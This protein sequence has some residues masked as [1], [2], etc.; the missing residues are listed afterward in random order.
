M[1]MTQIAGPSLG[2][3][4]VGP[5]A[6]RTPLR[7][8]S[9][10]PTGDALS[11]YSILAAAL[12]RTPRRRTSRRA[13][14]R[15]RRSGRSSICSTT[16]L[17]PNGGFTVTMRVANL[18]QTE[19]TSTR[20]PHAVAVA[21]LGLALHER[22][23]GRSG[24]GPLECRRRASRSATTTSRPATH[25]AIGGDTGGDK[26]ILY[27]GDQ[28]IQGDVN[29][30]TG[31]I[32]LSVPRFLLRALSGSTGPGERPSEVAA[33]VGSRFYDGT[34]FS[35]G[36]TI[37]PIQTLQSFLYP[38]DNTPS[39]D[40]LLPAPSGGGT[41]GVPCKIT[42]GGT[43]QTTGGKFSLNVHVGT[44]PKGSVSYR[45]ASTDFRSTSLSLATCADPSHA[46]I[47]GAGKNGND[48]VQF[49]LE[50]VDGGEASTNDAFSLTMTPGGN[51]SGTLSK[52]NIQIHKG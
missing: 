47:R 24:R 34:A 41:S 32:R 5:I 20:R 42:G 33:T 23:P 14:S 35:L 29:Q 6:N 28:P 45:D 22:L 26:C 9:V 43:L 10:D 25:L 50:V 17:S 48:P 30:A 37:S 8:S 7:T 12:G 36:N 49:V 52:G 1:A 38:L 51:R 18:A 19:L 39:M 11:S 16:R 46:E 2:G 3:G 27:P 21:A 40:F 13:T 4:T 31:T 15:Q 44:P